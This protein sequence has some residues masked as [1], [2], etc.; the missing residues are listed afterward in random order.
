MRQFTMIGTEK[1][2][3]Y[4]GVALKRAQVGFRDLGN[5]MFRIRIEPT[6][7]ERAALSPLFNNWTTGM[8]GGEFRFSTVVFGQ[9]ELVHRVKAALAVI[10]SP[11]RIVGS[12]GCPQWLL[13]AAKAS[14]K[15]TVNQERQ[16]LVAAVKEQKLAGCNFASR[17]SL[18]TLRQ[19]TA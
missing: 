6:A 8:G 5:N 17:W 7:R 10:N 9:T 13:E 19:K 3:E 12:D 1:T 2:G 4:V 16:R 11:G 15:E 18:A 14:K